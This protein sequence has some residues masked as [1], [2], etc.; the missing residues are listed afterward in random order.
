MTAGTTIVVADDHP[1]M[2]AAVS[3]ILECQEFTAGELLRM[4][5]RNEIRDANTLSICA[6]LIARGILTIAGSVGVME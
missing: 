2:L 6:R 3:E 4:I 1:A 5:G